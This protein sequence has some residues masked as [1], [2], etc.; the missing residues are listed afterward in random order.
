MESY[1][2]KGKYWRAIYVYSVYKV[3][4]RVINSGYWIYKYIQIVDIGELN[5]KDI[6]FIVSTYYRA[7]GSLPYFKVRDNGRYYCILYKSQ[8]HIFNRHG[9][10]SY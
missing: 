5:C 4:I 1:K 6:N 8:L 2:G 3:D 7:L 9:F 10:G